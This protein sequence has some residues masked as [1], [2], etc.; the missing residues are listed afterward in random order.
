MEHLRALYE[1][2]LQLLRPCVEVFLAVF[3]SSAYVSQFPNLSSR[4]SSG[5][6]LWATLVVALVGVV[7]LVL[8]PL[9]NLSDVRDQIFRSTSGA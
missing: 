1:E 2:G 4:I 9:L 3:I 6:A 8:I 5:P 7:S